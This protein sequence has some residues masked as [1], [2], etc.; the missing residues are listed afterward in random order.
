MWLE[1]MVAVIPFARM[2]SV[3]QPLYQ[4][5]TSHLHTRLQPLTQPHDVDDDKDGRCWS[6]WPRN[7]GPA[8][9]SCSWV[10]IPL[11]ML[12]KLQ[13][14][15]QALEK[16]CKKWW[17]PLHHQL[18][19]GL[20]WNIV[21]PEQQDLFQYGLEKICVTWA[22][23]LHHQLHL[24]LPWNLWDVLAQVEAVWHLNLNHLL[25]GLSGVHSP[26]PPC[27][28][29]ELL[30]LTFW[31]CWL[32]HGNWNEAVY[33]LADWLSPTCWHTVRTIEELLCH[34]EFPFHGLTCTDSR[35]LNSQCMT[36]TVVSYWITNR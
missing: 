28:L 7:I 33:E 16:T 29:L 5:M 17:R 36:I 18:L 27:L 14:A 1:M 22:R 26:R 25:W 23:L 34:S 6:S 24:A 20:P 12:P 4:E 35:T 21:L 19:L 2:V 9:L 13:D 8:F 10:Q 30:L 3:V 32:R 15:L 31:P 11:C